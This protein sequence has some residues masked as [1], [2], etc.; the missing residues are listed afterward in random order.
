MLLMTDIVMRVQSSVVFA[1]SF[2]TLKNFTVPGFITCYW[3]QTGLD[4]CVAL[5]TVI[6]VSHPAGA[7]ERVKTNRIAR[8]HD[9]CLTIIHSLRVFLISFHSF[10][11]HPV[12]VKRAKTNRT[13][14][15]GDFCLSI[16][17]SL[18]VF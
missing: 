18:C 14:H 3:T 4:L 16:I 1:R 9:F 5:F 17:H 12:G 13:V 6:V 8:V 11:P 2:L 10:V 7:G 15:M